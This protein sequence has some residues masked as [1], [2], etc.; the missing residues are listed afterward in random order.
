MEKK[1]RKWEI[2]KIQNQIKELYFHLFRYVGVK[3]FVLVNKGGVY[4]HKAMGEY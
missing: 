2:C 4:E 1:K 3:R